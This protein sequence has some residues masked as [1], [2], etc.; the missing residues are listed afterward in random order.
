MVARATTLASSL[1]LVTVAVM[2]DDA[3]ALALAAT[4]AGLLVR[5]EAIQPAAAASTTSPATTSTG[6]G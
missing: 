5:L 6:P 3:G 1:R 2:T 4:S